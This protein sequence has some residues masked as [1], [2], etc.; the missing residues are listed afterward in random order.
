MGCAAAKVGACRGFTGAGRAAMKRSLRV[1]GAP[2]AIALLTTMGLVVR[3]LWGEGGGV[4]S[5]VGVGSP[6]AVAAWVWL[7][8]QLAG[9]GALNSPA[10]YRRG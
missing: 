6:V 1:F 8:V 2:A 7:R 3:L 9:G 5:W 10:R 4:L